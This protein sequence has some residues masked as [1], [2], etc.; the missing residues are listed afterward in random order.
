MSS[1]TRTH[2]H[3]P[4]QPDHKAGLLPGTYTNLSYPHT[5][6]LLNLQPLATTTKANRL[7]KIRLRLH[8]A[9]ETMILHY[10]LLQNDHLPRMPPR[11]I[12]EVVQRRSDPGRKDLQEVHRPHSHLSERA[13]P[14]EQPAAL[15]RDSRSRGLVLTL[16]RSHKVRSI[17]VPVLRVLQHLSRNI[18]TISANC[19]YLSLNRRN[20]E[21]CIE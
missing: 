11:T 15:S 2:V 5:L 17:G 8:L 21:S 12:L 20:V 19:A 18:W 14:R 13:L 16:R 10:N 9:P 1:T 7:K 4:V 3:L 6:A